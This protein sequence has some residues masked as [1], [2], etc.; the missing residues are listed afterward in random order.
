[1]TPVFDSP[2]TYTMNSSAKSASRR[3]EFKP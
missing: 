3:R 1:M 2:K